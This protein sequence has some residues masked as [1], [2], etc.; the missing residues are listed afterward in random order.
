VF[1]NHL[2]LAGMRCVTCLVAFHV[3]LQ[4]HISASCRGSAHCAVMHPASSSSCY[5]LSHS[6]NAIDPAC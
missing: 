3:T 4:Q 6:T 2:G 5:Q 1:P